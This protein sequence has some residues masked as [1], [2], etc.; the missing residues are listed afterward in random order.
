MQVDNIKPQIKSAWFQ[1]LRLK[2]DEPLSNVAFEFNLRR[3]TKAAMASSLPSAGRSRLRCTLRQ[4][5]SFAE[6]LES[7]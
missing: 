3:Y 7:A 1:R 4:M 5:Y 2:C 6:S